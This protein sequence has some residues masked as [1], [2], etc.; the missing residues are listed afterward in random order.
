MVSWIDLQITTTTAGIPNSYTASID[1][2]P[3]IMIYADSDASGNAVN[4]TVSIG[5]STTSSYKMYIDAGPA[6]R[7]AS[8]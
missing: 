4:M 8:R 7:P 3:M 1:D 6:P 2:N 5:T